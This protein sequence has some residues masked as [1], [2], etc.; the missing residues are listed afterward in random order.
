MPSDD[1]LVGAR[2]PTLYERLRDNARGEHP[3][4]W[5]APAETGDADADADVVDLRR[6]P[7]PIPQDDSA[8]WPPVPWHQPDAPS[9]W[10]QAELPSE[11]Q[12]VRRATE[13]YTTVLSPEDGRAF[14]QWIESHPH[15]SALDTPFGPKPKYDW[16]GYWAATQRD[17]RAD[18]AKLPLSHWET[19]Y[20]PTFAQ[21]ATSKY[22]LPP[23]AA[24]APTA[25]L[26][27]DTKLDPK[28]EA[29][30]QQWLGAAGV[31]HHDDYDMR[32]LYQALRAGDPKARVTAVDGKL[33]FPESFRKKK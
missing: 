2:K 18:S 11:K 24:P 32:G 9:G 8:A 26:V 14:A 15:I 22:A 30:F 17:P 16:A 7:E 12:L 4:A 29:A 23:G 25:P 20:S 27:A 19:P 28:L 1:E 6:G 31:P 10:T 33:V 21:N 5:Y 3:Q 13:P